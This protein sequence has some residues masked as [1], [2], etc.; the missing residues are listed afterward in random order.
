MKYTVKLKTKAGEEAIIAF[1]GAF[2]IGAKVYGALVDVMGEYEYDLEE[3][4]EKE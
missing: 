1:Q 3:V 2:H 4:L